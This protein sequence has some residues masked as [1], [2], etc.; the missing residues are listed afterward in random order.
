MMEVTVSLLSARPLLALFPHLRLFS[1]S[2]SFLEL[3]LMPCT[4]DALNPLGS[5]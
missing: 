5:D 1:V 2:L 3:F 4:I